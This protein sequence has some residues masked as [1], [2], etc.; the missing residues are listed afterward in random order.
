MATEQI[1]VMSFEE[2]DG[3]GAR[4]D[5][6]EI[7]S[8]DYKAIADLDSGTV[9]SATST[10]VTDTTKTWVDNEWVDKLV[11]LECTLTSRFTYALVLSNTS[12]R[13][14]FDDPL[15]AEPTASCTYRIIDTV[16]LT[17]AD[18]NTIIACDIRDNT[19][20]V[21]LPL[22][23]VSIE[24][25]YAQV[26]NE[27]AN[28]GDHTTVVMC[29]GA[30]RQLGQKFGELNHR[31]EGVRLHAH[32]WGVPHWDV[33]QVFNVKRFANG[34]WVVAEAIATTAYEFL[35][36]TGKLTYEPPK[37]FM[38]LDVAGKQWLRYTSLLSRSFLI[39]TSV[40]VEKTGGGNSIIEIAYAK[41]SG[42]TGVVTQIT[43]RVGVA[44]LAVAGQATITTQF[45]VS[46]NHNDE[47]ILIAKRDTGTIEVLTGS[48]IDLIEL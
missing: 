31:Y 15:P 48:S 6:V 20:G 10:T 33:I 19:C 21:I 2:L 30:N 7:K 38:A 24:R 43:N 45:N 32:T 41:R 22:S 13:L 27:L 18:L 4:M 34:A 46:L 26:Y 28:N 42:S 40:V 11:R 23:K 12:T 29:R 36:D 14:T 16:V 35:G 17:D 1:G 9:T 44:K 25:R 37:R 5:S 3:L 39:L 47:I 8:I